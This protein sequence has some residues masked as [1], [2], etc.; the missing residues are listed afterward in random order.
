MSRGC[1]LSFSLGFVVLQ[2]NRSIEAR[3]KIRTKLY[4]ITTEMTICSL[5]TKHLQKKAEQ[6]FS[7]S[8]LRDALSSMCRAELIYCFSAMVSFGVTKNHRY[9]CLVWAQQNDNIMS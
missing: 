1:P 9:I 7:A 4:D 3:K 2:A 6:Q 8:L 5:Y